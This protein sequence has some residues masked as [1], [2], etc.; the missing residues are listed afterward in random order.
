MRDLSKEEAVY[1]Y[2][3]LQEIDVLRAVGEIKATMQNIEKLWDEEVSKYEETIMVQT[4]D[5]TTEQLR[6]NY[7]NPAGIIEDPSLFPYHSACYA[8]LDC[9]DTHD[10]ESDQDDALHSSEDDDR[11][12]R[13][14]GEDERVR[15]PNFLP[16]SINSIKDSLQNLTN[17]P[18][19]DEVLLR[20]LK[21][22]MAD[23][24]PDHRLTVEILLYCRDFKCFRDVQ[25]YRRVIA[26]VLLDRIICN[27]RCN[28]RRPFEPY[29]HLCDDWQ[30]IELVLGDAFCTGVD[31][32]TYEHAL[33]VC[34]F[35]KMTLDMANPSAG[36][37]DDEIVT[38]VGQSALKSR[39]A[40]LKQ[41]I[42][43]WKMTDYDDDDSDDESDDNNVKEVIPYR[44]LCEFVDALRRD[45]GKNRHRRWESEQAMNSFC[46][47]IGTF[48][49]MGETSVRRLPAKHDSIE[50]CS[51]IVSSFVGAYVYDWEHGNHEGPYILSPHLPSVI[52]P[53]RYANAVNQATER[54]LKAKEWET[55]VMGRG[56]EFEVAKK[57]PPRAPRDALDVIRSCFARDL[58]E[59][60]KA[61]CGYGDCLVWMDGEITAHDAFLFFSDSHNYPVG[62]EENEEPLIW[63]FDEVKYSPSFELM[64]FFFAHASS[65]DSL[66]RSTSFADALVGSL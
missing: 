21:H 10:D 28:V 39:K 58:A 56:P 16:N 46:N 57:A 38:N 48:V 54:F 34:A 49:F 23:F 33:L 6:R 45:A 53:D 13:S 59:V 51:M 41:A 52:N 24:Q 31:E 18:E 40:K 64:N 60:G 50:F 27:G 37:K 62:D 55:A 35:F 5:R 3:R 47:A 61:G 17:F 19:R 22:S 25:F 63:V 7:R 11:G 2:R 32:F 42:Y 15:V 14:G 20:L 66:G 12:F 8:L 44:V 9:Y 4:D 65:C 29:D 26:C 1:G 36:E 30:Q 43:L